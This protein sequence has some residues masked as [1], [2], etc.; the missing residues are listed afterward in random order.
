MKT[1]L[2]FSGVCLLYFMPAPPHIN[3][4]NSV[5]LSSYIMV[6]YFNVSVMWNRAYLKEQID[7]R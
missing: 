5:T 7:S 2:A 6:I 1:S 4:S 3:A